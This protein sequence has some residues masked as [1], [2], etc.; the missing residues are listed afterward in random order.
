MHGAG[1]DFVVI[2]AGDQ[3]RDWSRLA[4]EVCRRHF[5]IG[6]DGLLLVM[7]SRMADFRM[8][9]FNADGS[10]A[11]ACGNGI[12]CLVKYYVE[13]K[14]PASADGLVSI[15]TMAGVREAAYY[16]HG[17]RV[18]GVRV[19]M[20]IPRLIGHPAH[21]MAG[22]EHRDLLDITMVAERTI[23]V[24]GTELRLDLVS[25]GNHHAVCFVREPVSGFAL[26][27]IGGMLTELHAFSEGVNFEVARVLGPGTIEARVWEHG[28]GE[29][30]AC[31]S[32][33]CAIGVAAQRRGY[34]GSK[35]EV[36]LPGGTLEVEWDGS[37]EVFLTGPAETVFAG[38]WPDVDVVY[39]KAARDW[40]TKNEV[41]A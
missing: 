33:A 37:G 10:E 8:R 11:S 22:Q 27:R 18:S 17:A 5:G 41:L 38:D 3:E 16:R 21:E 24:D 14:M 34:V 23:V 40:H 28:V 25:I 32:G 20:G 19:G 1:N 31:G 4:V 26:S 39:D 15:E 29:T 9:I 12:R 6:A 7:P 30:M 2:E 13:G 35:A 36:R